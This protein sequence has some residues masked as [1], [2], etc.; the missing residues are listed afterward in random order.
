VLCK[1]QTECTISYN[2]DVNVRVR[3]STVGIRVRVG[4]MVR[5]MVWV[6]GMSGRGN[7]QGE[8][9]DTAWLHCVHI[10]LFQ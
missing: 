7:I 10:V 1:R 8:M 2:N 3:V 4:V 5:F 9:Y 6:R